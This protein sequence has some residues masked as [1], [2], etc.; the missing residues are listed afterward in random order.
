MSTFWVSFNDPKENRFLGVAIFDMDESNGE[1][2]TA[3]IVRHAWQLGIN[4][5]GAVMVRDVTGEACILD[6]HKNK[7]IT[8]GELLLRLRSKG[9]K[10]LS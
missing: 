9:R 6:E 4:P 1:L 10:N 3:Q 8:D 5:G 7:L 2:S